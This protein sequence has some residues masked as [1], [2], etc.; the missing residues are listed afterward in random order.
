[1]LI[2]RPF[3]DK[4]YKTKKKQKSTHCIIH[5]VHIS[6]LKMHYYLLF[7]DAMYRWLFLQLLKLNRLQ[8]IYVLISWFEKLNHSLQSNN[9]R[10]KM[11][12]QIQIA[13]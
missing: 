7:H 1:M 2:Y 8:F 9:D 13:N 5:I 11:V 4:N 3:D 6:L 12:P 10:F